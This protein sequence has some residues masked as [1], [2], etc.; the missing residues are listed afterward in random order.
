MDQWTK[1]AH[2][3]QMLPPDSVQSLYPPNTFPIEARYYAAEWIDN[4]RWEDYSLDRPEM[5]NN[6]RELLNITRMELQKIANQLNVV[7][8]MKLLHVTNN[9]CNYSSNALQ[10]AVL[11]RDILRKERELINSAD[12]SNV[13]IQTP[14]YNSTGTSFLEAKVHELMSLRQATHSQQ[15]ELNWEKQNLDTLEKQIRQGDQSKVKTANICKQHT[16]KLEFEID[17]LITRRARCMEECVN[18]L[19]T[20]QMDY[21]RNLEEWKFA[22]HKSFVG[23]P[24]NDNLLPLQ[25][26]SEQLLW[27]IETLR[28]ELTL[29]ATPLPTCQ[30]QLEK[31]LQSLFD[32][33]L[34]V[35]KQ[36]PQVIKTQSKFSTAVRCLLGEKVVPGKP[37]VIK[38]QVINELQAKNLGNMPSEIVAELINNQSILEK[39]PGNKTT[40]ATFR[41]MSVKKIKRA[42]RKGSES[43]TEEKFAI[44]FSTEILYN[45][46]ST[47]YMIQMISLPVVI[48]VHGSQDSN[49][50][51][52]ILWDCAFARPE[53]VPFAVPDYVSWR[54]MCKTLNYKFISEVN[55]SHNLDKFNQHFL[56]Q[57]IFDKPEFNGDFGEMMVSWAQFNKEVL[58]GRAFTFWQWFEGVTELS[59]RHLSPYWN[60]GLIFG[61]I[62]K[63][64]LHMI[65]NDSPTGTFLLR[66]SDSEIG[67]ITIAYVSAGVGGQKIQNIQPFCKKDLEIRNLADRIGDIAEISYLYPNI[68]KFE[69]FGKYITGL[70]LRPPD[71]YLPATLQTKVVAPNNTA[72][73]NGTPA[74]PPVA[75]IPPAQAPQNREVTPSYPV[76]PVTPT[77]ADPDSF[78]PNDLEELYSDFGFPLNVPANGVTMDAMEN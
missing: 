32:N 50:L 54:E 36:P 33:S 21:L 20:C 51:A 49:A 30:L 44:L 28:G 45:G 77:I 35:E 43:V 31:L 66:F 58:P 78:L 13:S 47:P 70:P 25:T 15:E 12:P 75:S 60:D 55:T 26:W 72:P 74:P 59:K 3:L 24:F 2:I 69:A 68:S 61:F 18:S 34:I 39:N 53:R 76:N 56:A 65:L 62:G 42:D 40:C 11:V 27:V 10:F 19:Q 37:V 9:M 29:I 73:G 1:I 41:N 5:E 57:K 7:E 6:A 8:K 14:E 46:C 64:H 48:T 23:F 52:T 22:Q 71:G 63:H 38:A 16:M 67:G 17:Q 4:Q